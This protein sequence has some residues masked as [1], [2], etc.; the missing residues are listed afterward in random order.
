MNTA[1]IRLRQLPISNSQ[2]QKPG[3]VEE[4]LQARLGRFVGLRGEST[5]AGKR[6]RSWSVGPTLSPLSGTI[7]VEGQHVIFC[8]PRIES[9]SQKLPVLPGAQGA[10]P[11]SRRGSIRSRSHALLRVLSLRTR[12]AAIAT[13]RRRRPAA[14]PRLPLR[15]CLRR[16]SDCAPACNVRSP[17]GQRARRGKERFVPHLAVWNYEV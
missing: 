2:L 14:A 17:R 8:H 7:A 6:G 4:D 13:S 5:A 3:F 15:P 12:S 10:I 1:A 16:S 11:V 9:R